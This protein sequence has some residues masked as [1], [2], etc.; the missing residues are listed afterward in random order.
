MAIISITSVWL[1]DIKMGYC[2]SGWWLNKKFCCQ[3]V[4]EEGELCEEWTTWGGM[5]PFRYIAYIVYAVSHPLPSRWA[6]RKQ[7]AVLGPGQQQWWQ[8]IWARG[9]ISTKRRSVWDCRGYD[10]SELA[11]QGEQSPPHLIHFARSRDRTFASEASVPL[12]L[13]SVSPIISQSTAH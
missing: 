8:V 1:S 10:R 7:E 13:A 3:E 9:R 11:T 5:E 12:L 6:V 2:S 4:S